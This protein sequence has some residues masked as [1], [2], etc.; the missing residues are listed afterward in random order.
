MRTFTDITERKNA[1][2]RLEIAK[3]EA[4]TASDLIT[5]IFRTISQGI[6]VLD[7]DGQILACN[8]RWAELTD[9]PEALISPPPHLRDIIKF[10]M[11]FGSHPHLTGS[12]DQRIETRVSQILSLD[13]GQIHQYE[14]TTGRYLE[15][16]SSRISQ[17]R[18][19]DTFTDIT[20]H[21]LQ[22]ALLADAKHLAEEANRAKSAFLASMSH[23]IRTPLSGITGFLELLQYSDLTADQRS[24]VRSVNLSAKHLIDLI[25]DVLDFSKI[26]AGHLDLSMGEVSPRSLLDEVI[27]VVSPLAQEKLVDLHDQLSPRTPETLQAD[28]VRL[29]QI[30]VNL[31]GNAVK[32]SE[33][34]A[35]HIDVLP[36]RS[37]ETG[38]WSVWFE[39][40]DT[41]IGFD[42]ISTPDLFGEFRQADDSTTRRFGGTGL[43]LAISK[44]LVEMMGGEIGYDAEPERGAWF[45]FTIPLNHAPPQPASPKRSSELSV[46]L[47]GENTEI[48]SHAIDLTTRAGFS[49]ELDLLAVPEE[50]MFD[51]A[52]VVDRL[53]DAAGREFRSYSKTRILISA[54]AGFEAKNNALHAGFT[55]ILSREAWISSLVHHVGESGRHT[56][57]PL[58]EEFN[59]DIS[60][61]FSQLLR[62]SV[63]N[64][65]ILVIDDIEMNRQI[66]GRQLDML[67]LPHEFAN[68]GEQGLAKVRENR[69]AAVI[70]DVSMPIMDGYEFTKHFRLLEQ[71]TGNVEDRR[72]T[73]VALTAN[74]TAD[75]AEKCISAGMDDYMSK[76]LTMGRLSQ[77]LIKWLGVENI[78]L[79]PQKIDDKASK[80]G[81]SPS[82]LEESDIDFV[83]LN[84]ILG[85]DDPEELHEYL[86][87]FVTH[88]SGYLNELDDALEARNEDLT[89]ET[90]HTMSGSAKYAGAKSLAKT[91][92][93][94]ERAVGSASW[95]ELSFMADAA[96]SQ[97]SRIEDIAH[98]LETDG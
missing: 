76:P 40:T 95:E 28:P 19:V 4:E 37:G 2:R 83:E 74:V 61:N 42:P 71:N 43:G 73:V 15:I 59:N 49:V 96:R 1:E 90:A 72:T 79:T 56:N 75:D 31:V 22:E 18:R 36:R 94:I 41:G 35:V 66:A 39:V 77:M 67:N 46:L 65:P 97:L 84:D 81:V 23:E 64:L 17:G 50:K 87:E 82:R 7:E 93:S 25:G 48:K 12:L 33:S 58:A 29:R 55:Q 11:E 44:R 88:V 13:D 80:S 14:T 62:P 27:S 69:Y 60:D 51:A 8:A 89:R 24:M 10:Q 34:G 5:S 53:P 98:R 78:D 47:L 26:E 21:R 85:T 38:E 91:C 30:L 54:D 3:N 70:V 86:Q 32:F 9:L 63:A 68:D 92:F 52:V 57:S 6:C 20:E 45:W 16:Q